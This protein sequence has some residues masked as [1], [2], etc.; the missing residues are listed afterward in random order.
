MSINLNQQSELL[1]PPKTMQWQH[2][3]DQHYKSSN[4]I[5]VTSGGSFTASTSQLTCAASWP[6]FVYDRCRL[7]CVID[8]SYAGVGNEYIAD[9]IITYFQDIPEETYKNYL[10]IVMWT[11]IGWAH[12]K[13][14]N[15][16]VNPKIKNVSYAKKNIIPTKT[17]YVEDAYLSYS[18]IIELYQYLHSNNIAFAFTYYAN[19]LFPPCLPRSDNTTTFLEQLSSKEIKNLQKLNWI[20]KNTR[21]Y[22][23]DY[24]IFQNYSNEYHPSV[25][26]NLAWTDNVLLPEL[27]IQGLIAKFDMK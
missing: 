7:D 5:L 23:Y 16:N 12:N 6:G 15:G 27:E 26:C 1:L 24:S 22:L 8:L 17:D 18:R 13:I 3:L 10:V 9:S 25:E 19:V 20:P 4:K 21:D 14:I 2:S 11:G